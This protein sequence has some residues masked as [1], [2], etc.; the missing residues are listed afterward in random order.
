MILKGIPVMA[1]KIPGNISILKNLN[2]KLN[3]NIGDLSEISKILKAEQFNI[4]PELLENVIKNFTWENRIK[5]IEK[6]YYE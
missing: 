3:F 4:N 1:S 2:E 6:I 5:D